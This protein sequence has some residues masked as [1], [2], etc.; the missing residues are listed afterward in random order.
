MQS[1]S[2]NVVNCNELSE[3]EKHY[4][5]I[6][7]TYAQ[8]ALRNQEVPVGCIFVYNNE[9]VA[10]GRNTVNETRN[11]TRHAEMNCIDDVI[12]YCED[13]NIVSKEVFE[14]VSVYVTVEPCIM[15]AAAL[16]NLKI[17]QIL[18]GCR[19]DRFG[20]QTV[21]DVANVL[22][23][24]TDV[25]GGYRADEAMALLKEFYKG[26]NPSAPPNKVKIKN[27]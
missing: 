22:N 7:F 13:R 15:C 8:D 20:G 1:S 6:A 18:F 10:K 2:N 17:K 3:S 14:N 9:I 12:A 5:E 21:F 4:M 16:Y 11:A 19:N 23:P 26:T 24:V 25:K 27:I